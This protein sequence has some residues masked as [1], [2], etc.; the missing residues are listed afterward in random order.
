MPIVVD[1]NYTLFKTPR[2]GVQLGADISTFSG[3]KVLGPEGIGVV[4][5]K[6]RTD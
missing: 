6:K 3:F 4:A 5:G 2:I 1:D